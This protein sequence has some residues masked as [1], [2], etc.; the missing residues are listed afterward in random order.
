MSATAP[1]ADCASRPS[2]DPDRLLLLRRRR[3]IRVRDDRRG[4]EQAGGVVDAAVGALGPDAVV[5]GAG[6][7]VGRVVALALLAACLPSRVGALVDRERGC[8]GG[9][10]EP[11]DV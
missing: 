9:D 5:R 2:T 1:T 8:P 7:D 6:E 3:L 4:I 10:A 11:H